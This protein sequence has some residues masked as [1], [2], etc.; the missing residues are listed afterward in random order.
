MLIK[1]PA[2]ARGHADHGWLNA[3]HTFSFANYY[4]PRHQG[5]R[6]LRVINED[7]IAPAAG[8]GMHGHQDM[9]IITWLLGGSLRHHDSLGSGAVLRPGDAQVMSAGTGI[10]HSEVNASTSEPAHLLQIWIEPRSAG[11][12]PRYADL[13]FP[14]AERS[15]RLR[16][17]ATGRLGAAGTSAAS[18][19]SAPGRD[20][21]LPIHADADV[22]VAN[23]NPGTALSHDLAPGRHAWIQVAHGALTVNGQELGAGDGLAV[24]DQARLDLTAKS[25]AEILLFDLG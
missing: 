18:G 9:E 17:I 16:P 7:R 21:S 13:H 22:F 10:R 15:D 3:R 4:D 2:L 20:G 5:F 14:L 1:R 8:F 19:A 23:L 12:G 6:A 11:I 24:S 25:P